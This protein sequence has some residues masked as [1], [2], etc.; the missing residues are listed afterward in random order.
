MGMSLNNFRRELRQNKRLFLQKVTQRWKR[1][2]RIQ[3]NW[4]V[5]QVEFFSCSGKLNYFTQ[6]MYTKRV[7]FSSIFCLSMTPRNLL[8]TTT[9]IHCTAPQLAMGLPYSLYF[10]TWLKGCED[11]FLQNVIIRFLGWERWSRKKLFLSFT[12]NFWAPYPA[13]NVTEPQNP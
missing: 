7:I 11:Y 13:S 8:P 5:N 1:P 4:T 3:V 6:P 10:T 12:F 9:R 2:T